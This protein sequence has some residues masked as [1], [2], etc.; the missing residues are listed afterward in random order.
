MTNALPWTVPHVEILTSSLFCYPR[1]ISTLASLKFSVQEE[2]AASVFE[3]FCL[4]RMFSS[5]TYVTS[6]NVSVQRQLRN[7]LPGR[8]PTT[9]RPWILTW[10]GRIFVWWP[11]TTVRECVRWWLNSRVA[12]KPISFWPFL[13][14]SNLSLESWNRSLKKHGMLESSI[15]L[16]FLKAR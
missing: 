1:R 8:F 14:D 12:T 16:Y 5:F 10:A 7:P 4:N 2:T 6:I 9:I 15:L 11:Q 3:K 13:L